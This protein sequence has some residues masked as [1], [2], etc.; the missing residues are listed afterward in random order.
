MELEG[1]VAV[2]TGAGN[3]IGRSIALALAQRGVG[4]VVADI[5]GAAARAVAAEVVELGQRAIGTAI[6]VSDPEAVEGLADRAFGEFG[7]VDILVNNAGVSM[8]PFR[9]IWD[10]SVEDYRWMTDVNYLGV[11]WGLRAFIPRM[12]RQPGRK[13][14]VNTSSLAALSETPGHGAYAAAKTAVTAISDQLRSEF[15]DYEEKIGVTVLHPGKVET[16]I[17]EKSEG[18]RAPEDRS[19]ARDIPPYRYVRDDD[20]AM[21]VVIDPEVVGEMVVEAI[22]ADAPYVLTHAASESYLRE[23]LSW[24]LDGCG[25]GL[26]DRAEELRDHDEDRGVRR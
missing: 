8:R 13:H 24:A 21:H 26:R 18:F 5:A 25:Y 16:R 12:R 2:V 20:Q 19:D 14:I 6:D 15:R 7:R 22:L 1:A 23:R 9:T 17:V 4:I 11:V 3:G 10:A